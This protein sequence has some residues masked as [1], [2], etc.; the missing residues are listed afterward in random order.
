MDFTATWG[1]PQWTLLAVLILSLLYHC[2]RHGDPRVETQ[3]ERKGQP[4]RFNGFVA[5]TRFALL[6]FVLIAGGFF[7]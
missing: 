6:M 7:S 2:H 4:E 3:G 5:L 1:W